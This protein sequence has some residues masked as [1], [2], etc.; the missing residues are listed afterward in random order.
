MLFAITSASLTFE[1]LVT[2]RN[3]RT[4][5]PIAS[6][7]T[8]LGSATKRPRHAA[9]TSVNL[10]YHLKSLQQRSAESSSE[11]ITQQNDTFIENGDKIRPESENASGQNDGDRCPLNTN[12]NPA[13]L[14]GLEQRPSSSPINQSIKAA[15][16]M[17]IHD[18][19]T[20]Q[21]PKR[22]DTGTECL[23]H[24]DCC[25]NNF[26]D[27]SPPPER[28]FVGERENDSD[29]QGQTEDKENV[30]PTRD[31]KAK[32]SYEGKQKSKP[33]R[34]SLEPL[35]NIF[36]TGLLPNNSAEKEKN[37]RSRNAFITSQKGNAFRLITPSINA[38]KLNSLAP[39]SDCSLHNENQVGRKLSPTDGGLHSVFK[40]TKLD[41]YTEYSFF[42]SKS[43]PL[44]PG[45][46]AVDVVY[47][48]TDTGEPEFQSTKTE[49]LVFPSTWK[50]Y[51]PSLHD[52]F[53]G[54]HDEDDHVEATADVLSTYEPPNPPHS[55]L[56]GWLLRLGA[57]LFPDDDDA[58]LGTMDGGEFFYTHGW[59]LIQTCCHD[60]FF[61]VHDELHYIEVSPEELSSVV[62]TPLSSG[63]HAFVYWCAELWDD[64]PASIDDME[65]LFFNW[66]LAIVCLFAFMPL[67]QYAADYLLSFDLPHVHNSNDC[68]PAIVGY[69]SSFPCEYLPTYLASYFIKFQSS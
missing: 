7:S 20:T 40:P 32:L 3:A 68:D 6:A 55:T 57:F 34:V 62:M 17:S 12:S 33:N 65:F 25:E 5:N 1:Y 54:V 43:H 2:F 64:T 23:S 8:S 41:Y 47:H 24:Q 29:V 26:L 52:V 53:Y 13:S 48:D 4:V 14:D 50:A 19:S 35:P 49:D 28:P 31:A 56:D 22:N 10:E 63:K 36:S 42:S 59:L 58:Q 45:N 18:G 15:R 38:P 11:P 27:L 39:R 51:L 21:S 30:S 16:D 46:N 66:L 61:G 69:W 60:V 44:L 37:A 67:L 9:L